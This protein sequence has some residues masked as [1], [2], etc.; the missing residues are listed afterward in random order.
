MV[1]H[2]GRSPR[3]PTFQKVARGLIGIGLI[4]PVHGSGLKVEGTPDGSW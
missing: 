3:H 1:V 4:R 2:G